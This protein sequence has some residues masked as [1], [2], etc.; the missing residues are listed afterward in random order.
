MCWLIGWLLI[1]NAMFSTVWYFAT[2]IFGGR[3]PS[4]PSKNQDEQLILYMW[5]PWCSL[6]ILKYD[7][8]IKMKKRGRHCSYEIG[9]I[10]D[11]LGQAYVI[12]FNRLVIVC[13]NIFA[14]W[15]IRFKSAIAS[16]NHGDI[17]FI[18]RRF[19]IYINDKCK[20]S[21]CVSWNHP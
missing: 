14:A 2:V 5:H 16:N 10:R 18:F 3:R 7:E 12:T 21:Q 17:S 15:N 19:W 9:I 6:D 4:C 20:T 8:D 11:H 13:V 1:C